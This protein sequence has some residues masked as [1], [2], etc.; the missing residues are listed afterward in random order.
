MKRFLTML[1]ALAAAAL[2]AQALWHL[3]DLRFASGDVYPPGS[4][5]RSDPLGAQAYYESLGLLPGVRTERL[6]EPLHRL[7]RGRDTTLFMLACEPAAA[8]ILSA[9]DAL[10]LDDFL[11]QGGRVVVTFQPTSGRPYWPYT[12]FTRPPVTATNRPAPGPGPQRKAAFRA[13]AADPVSFATHWNFHF[14]YLPL[15]A[16][17]DGPPAAVTVARTEAAPDFLPASIA[18]HSAAVFGGHDPDWTV[19]YTRSNQPVVLTRT[20]GRGTLV[21]AGDSFLHSNE[22]LRRGRDTALLV[23]LA[24][25]RHRLVFEETHLGSEVSPGLMTLARRYRLHGLG[26]GLLLL[27]GLFVWRTAT[28]LLP[29]LPEPADA[30]GEMVTGRDSTTGFV[31]LLRRAVTPADLLPLCLEEWKKTMP[32]GRAD[33]TR[34]AAALQD[35]VNLESARPAKSQNPVA[36]YRTL[37]AILTQR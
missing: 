3:F 9:Q 26:A 1:T 22:A 35:V 15:P 11:A 34:K 25:D 23:W 28:S 4:S 17:K 24:G 31:N 6:L 12:G 21:L 29:R 13:G 18:W 32:R 36:T 30:D 19:L 14:D 33:L 16:E 37:S 5:F 10:E 7:G 20:L 2:F 8:P 27:A